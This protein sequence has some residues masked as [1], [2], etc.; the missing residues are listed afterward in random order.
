M[1]AD[2]MAQRRLAIS[3][4]AILLLASFA[5][6]G[7][8][9]E[10]GTI[11]L[12]IA[13]GAD[14]A[15]PTYDTRRQ[16]FLA[17]NPHVELEWVPINVAD[18]S[19]IGMDARI[20]S[21][22][23]IHFYHD[24]M[25]RAGKFAVPKTEEDQAIWALDLSKYIDDLDDYRPGVLD[26]LWK[27]GKIYAVP[28]G[29]LIVGQ[30]LNLTVM[31]NAGYKPPP[32]EG[33]TLE[34]FTKCAQKTKAAQIPDTYATLMFA[35]NRSGDWM[36]MGWLASLGA[37]LFDGGDYSKTIIDSPE[38]LKVFNFWKALQDTG[39]IP[40]DAAMMND[41][42]AIEYRNAG[43]LGVMG[44][45][46]G[47]VNNPVYQQQ[48]VDAGMIEEPYKT[49]F[50]PYPKGPTVEKVPLF[51]SYELSVAFDTGTEEEKVMAARLVWHQT[52]TV[53]QS[54]LCNVNKL[55]T[56]KSV[57]GLDQVWWREVN[58]LV[59][60]N[61]VMDVGGHLGC[62]NEIRGAMFPV[63]Q[64]LFMDKASPAE[65][66]KLYADVLNKILSENQ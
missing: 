10:A 53:A 9:E 35:E 48:L 12:F 49:A 33:W 27:D 1:E 57:T 25:S 36:Y 59:A 17:E 19:T 14:I 61:G 6:A 3:I 58:A 64:A 15:S 66:V 63:L 31:E 24:Y 41:D 62:Y 40:Y 5:F 47:D 42:H 32:A 20:A 22:L 4:L 7:G 51:T 43:R 26:T 54:F 65:A 45:R 2:F 16:P 21:G 44:D 28:N 23:P 37:R 34:E 18:A 39:F 11:K 30:R 13:L 29:T 56:R 60:A 55:S 8:Q 50:Y 52:N 38:G 46:A